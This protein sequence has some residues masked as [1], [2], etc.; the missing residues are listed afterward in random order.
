[1]QGDQFRSGVEAQLVGEAIA[2]FGVAVQRLGLP[3]GRVQGAQLQRPQ[4][5]PQRVP[6]DQFG[7]VGGDQVVLA[8]GEAGVGEPLV[9]GE[10]LLGQPGRLGAD[11]LGVGHVG[12]RIAA[13]QVQRRGQPGGV[14]G[15]GQLGEPVRVH[16][17][18][19]AG[20][21]R[22][23]GTRPGRGRPARRR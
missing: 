9:H 19:C 11:V 16:R 20:R 12:V 2:Q 23:G 8:A 17:R 15:G 5:L 13:P 10:A 6:G 22:A 21:T 14:L 18:R 1:M 4:A 3:A 7:Q